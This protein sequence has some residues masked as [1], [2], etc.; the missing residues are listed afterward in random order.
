MPTN[1]RGGGNDYP[2]N[3]YPAGF[4]GMPQA[5]PPSGGPPGQAYDP[6]AAAQFYQYYQ[7]YFNQQ[8]GQQ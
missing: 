8:Q 5:P 2:S 3:N 6:V 4:P 1:N 7:Y